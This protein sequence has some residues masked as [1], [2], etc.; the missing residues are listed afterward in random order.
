MLMEL[1]APPSLGGSTLRG[2]IFVW[3]VTFTVILPGPGDLTPVQDHRS[4]TT[5]QGS[6]SKSIVM[7]VHWSLVASLQPLDLSMWLMI[8]HVWRVPKVWLSLYL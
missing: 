2:A 4:A 8:L 6:L 3:L 7:T 1:S 5:G